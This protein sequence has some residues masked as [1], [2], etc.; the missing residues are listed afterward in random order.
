[1]STTT[2]IKGEDR[3][4]ERSIVDESGNAM[5]LTGYTEITA[6]FAGTAGTIT[7]TETGGEISVTNEGGGLIEINLTDTH[8]DL[9][10]LGSQSYEVWVDIGTIRRIFQYLKTLTILARL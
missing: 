2:I 7:L 5:D 10:S 4:L 6:T 1:M 8:T 9:L 3:T